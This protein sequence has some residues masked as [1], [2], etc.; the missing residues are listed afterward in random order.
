MP[1]TAPT[2]ISKTVAGRLLVLTEQLSSWQQTNT[3]RTLAAL[4]NDWHK[5]SMIIL[6]DTTK[7]CPDYK[8]LEVP[9]TS[10]FSF[11]DSRYWVCQAGPRYSPQSLCHLPGF[12]QTE[13][14]SIGLFSFSQTICPSCTDLL[15]WPPSREP[16][17]E[18]EF[19]TSQIGFSGLREPSLR[20][21]LRVF[22]VAS[23]PVNSGIA[24][25][26]ILR[27]PFSVSVSACLLKSL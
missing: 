21:E 14:S 9:I 10:G 8:V 5:L 18:L 4:F 13:L 20:R 1:H 6:S 26:Q 27:S 23:I 15:R 19:D 16:N 25:F 11:G 7:F 24:G 22:R 2:G 17:Q 3:I 12:Y